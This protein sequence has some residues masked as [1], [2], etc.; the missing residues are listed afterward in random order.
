[1][2]AIRLAVA[3]LDC[4]EEDLQAMFWTLDTIDVLIGALDDFDRMVVEA[5]ATALLHVLDVAT[6]K[7]N[8]DAGN[9]FNDVCARLRSL[10]L[11]QKLADSAVDHGSVGADADLWGFVKGEKE[12]DD[13]GTGN[14]LRGKA[15]GV[16]TKKGGGRVWR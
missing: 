11:P 4:G 1:M 14:I 13:D 8:E 16:D 9:R 5:A 6:Q 3:L 7:A 2:L 10:D 15:D 12:V